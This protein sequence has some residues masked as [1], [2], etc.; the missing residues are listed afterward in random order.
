MEAECDNQGSLDLGSQPEC[1]MED[2]KARICYTE[3]RHSSHRLPNI[4]IR[5]AS[6]RE[7]IDFIGESSRLKADIAFRAEFRMS[8]KVQNDKLANL[9]GRNMRGMFRDCADA[10]ALGC[11]AAPFNLNYLKGDVVIR[12]FK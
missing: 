6:R 11:V 4:M 3:P 2:D 10:S 8:C 7:I 5:S 12:S 9:I 1:R